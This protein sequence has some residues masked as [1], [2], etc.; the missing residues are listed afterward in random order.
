MEADDTIK[1]LFLRIFQGPPAPGPG[2]LISGA[3]RKEGGGE[4]KDEHSEPPPP[5]STPFVTLNHG[6]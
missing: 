1:R 4:Q 6:H 2:P 5:G 3:K